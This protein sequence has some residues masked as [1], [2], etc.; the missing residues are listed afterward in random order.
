M[1]GRGELSLVM[2]GEERTSFPLS[3]PIVVVCFLWLFFDFFDCLGGVISSSSSFSLFLSVFLVSGD[4]GGVRR[5]G[6][7]MGVGGDFLPGS[8]GWKLFAMAC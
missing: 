1:L 2:S 8:S 7:R 3:L 5:S 6:D 4:N